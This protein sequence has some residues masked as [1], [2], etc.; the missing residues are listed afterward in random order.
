MSC[1]L[2]LGMSEDERVQGRGESWSCGEGRDVGW[3]GRRRDMYVDGYGLGKGKERFH[4]F[5]P[6]IE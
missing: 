3:G 6:G 1:H 2:C 4:I 5:F